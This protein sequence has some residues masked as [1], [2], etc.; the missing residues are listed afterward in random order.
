MSSVPAPTSTAVPDIRL[1]SLEDVVGMVPYLLGFH[2]DDSLV[3]IGL[4]AADGRA[5]IEVVARIDRVAPGAGTSTG[6]GARSGSEE[7]TEADA[8]VAQTLA[9]VRRSG[10]ARAIALVYGAEPTE[11]ELRAVRRAARCTDVGL[12]DVI[13]VGR[14]RWRSV[15]CRD[16]DCCPPTGRPLPTAPT[17][18]HAA[19]TVAGMV[20]RPSRSALAQVLQPRPEADRQAMAR[21]VRE[22]ARRREERI[23]STSIGRWQRSAVRSVFGA[24]RRL[25]VLDDAQ[26]AQQLVALADTAVRDACWLAVDEGRIDGEGLWREL[27]ARA[28]LPYSTGPLFL[29][30]WQQWRRGNGT[31]A[32]IAAERALRADPEYRAAQ[33]L[34]AALQ[35]GLN[36]FRSKRLRSYRRSGQ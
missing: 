17:A 15:L 25:G 5:R 33:L 30:A 20:A 1:R 9:A 18:A 27:A 29:F 22:A 13:A 34:L 26:A 35:Q 3:L 21:W 6:T 23:A 24:T 11:P 31:L 2:P 16:P 36:P 10:A 8:H 7:A 32:G 19:A 4:S 14:G 12:A 28:P